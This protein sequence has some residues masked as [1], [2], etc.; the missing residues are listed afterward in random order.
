M[1][2]RESG[3]NCLMPSI[4]THRLALLIGLIAW[5]ACVGPAAAQ[6]RA[7][8]QPGVFDYYLLSLS[9]SP[10]FC[11][12][13]KGGASQLQCGAR[14]YSFV[15]HGL[16]PQFNKG[17]P[18]SCQV[19]PPRLDRRIV[20][21]MLD[22]MPAPALIYHEW[23]AH[24]TCSGLSARDYFDTVRKAR[25]AVTIPPEYDHPQAPLTVTPQ[26][27]ADSFRKANP[28]LSAGGI[29]IDCDRTRLRE[30]RIC[31]SRD[32]QFHDCTGNRNACRSEKLVMPP[33]RG[34]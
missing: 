33:V 8:N 4:G 21:N 20:D 16:W 31:F 2:P 30:V 15:V 22:L 25:A 17:F 5:I 32:L 7:Q 11:E 27:V 19:P 34:Q 29:A 10:S 6:G 14:P 13:S 28:G 23:D 18:E 3:D 12:T 1:V 24:G 9:W 26:E